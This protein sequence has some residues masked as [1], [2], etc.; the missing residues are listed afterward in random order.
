MNKDIRVVVNNTL[1]LYVMQVSKYVF[2]L[3]TF[4]YLTRVLQPTNYGIITFANAVMAYFQ[5]FI[6]F[7]FLQSATRDCSYF[8]HDKD[9]LA[10]IVGSVIQA[11]IL[12]W[13]VGLVIIFTLVVFSNVFLGRELYILLSYIPVFLGI[14]IADYLFRG[15][16]TMKIITYRT[17]IGRTIYTALLFLF[18]RKAELYIFIPLITSF[19]EV[20]IIIWTMYYI[21]NDIGLKL[22]IVSWNETVSALKGSAIFFLS[23]IATTAY[24]STNIVVLGLLYDNAMLAQFG[25]A[26]SLISNIRSMFSPI[27]DSLYPYMIQKKNYTLVGRTLVILMPVVLIGTVCLYFVAGPIIVL[28]AGEDYLGAIPIFQAFLPVVLITLPVYLLGFPV[29]GA[30]NR[31]KDANYSTIASGLYHIAGI[32]ILYITGY[33]S[34]ISIALLTFSTELLVLVYR[35][36]C[37]INGAAEK[38][39]EKQLL[40]KDSI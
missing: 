37:I 1:L 35:V 4:P 14:F 21:Y 9:R 24:S 17:I 8:R 39:G 34:F 38:R 12:L 22:K 5:M 25:V 18:V 27:A 13:L 36:I 31:M 40:G 29:L 6:D 28:M 26:N 2:P 3:I 19:G 11:K 23:R 33:C 32:V 30:M 7:G 15:L 16:E 10:L 20:I